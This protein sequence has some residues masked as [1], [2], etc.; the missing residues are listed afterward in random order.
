LLFGEQIIPKFKTAAASAQGSIVYL[1]GV[2]VRVA[3]YAKEDFVQARGELEAM[4]RIGFHGGVVQLYGYS[5]SGTHY[6]VVTEYTEA[7]SLRN[8][9]RSKVNNNSAG[10]PMELMSVVKIGISLARAMIVLH[11]RKIIHRSLTVDN[12]L[13]ESFNEAKLKI[14]GF[15]FSVQQTPPPKAI[16]SPE[17]S[18]A[19][20]APEI[21]EDEHSNKVDI[22]SFGK[23]LWAMLVGSEP[24]IPIA[25]ETPPMPPECV[26]CSRGDKKLCRLKNLMSSC[27]RLEPEA[28]PTFKEIYD[29]LFLLR[30]TMDWIGGKQ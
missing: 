16:P 12:I 2:P 8:F 24:P 14:T 22:F 15:R 27:W 3:K 11:S 5:Q 18:K 20:A 23:I 13:V 4:R 26:F 29:Q 10:K 9:L 21:T 28:R 7:G 19:Y 25:L 17:V 6:F 30:Q 1:K